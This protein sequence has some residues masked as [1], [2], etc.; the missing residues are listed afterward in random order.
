MVTEGNTAAAG[1]RIRRT[2]AADWREVRELRLEM[3]A[4]TPI[5]FGETLQD[6]LGH[7]DSEWRMRGAR[8]TAEH[9]IALVAID[10]DGRWVATM[11]G[12]I[13]DQAA[14]PTL[15]G[16]YVSPGHRGRGAGVFDL[17]LDTIETWA[18]TKGAVLTLQV[19]EDNARA[20]AA[21][22]RRG[23]TET[24]RRVP[25]P[26]DTAAMQIEMVKRL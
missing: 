24:G 23:F 21:Y 14:G 22:L 12:F 3:L 10:P 16:V 6:A 8:G 9:G 17:L 26:L 5:A 7:P 2:V 18:R 19:H 25:Y 20:R 11:A 13:P 4:D 15:V 1:Y